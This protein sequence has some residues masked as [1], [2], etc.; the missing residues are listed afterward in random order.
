M[1]L[2]EGKTPERRSILAELQA[3]IGG[4][5]RAYSGIL[6]V[7]HAAIGFMFLCATFWF[8]N[9]G[10]AGLIAAAIGMAVGYVL[11]LPYAISGVNVYSSL[12]VGLSLGAFY[13]L[14]A[15]LIVLIAL[16]AALTVLLAAALRDVLWRLGR[17]PVLSVPFVIVALTTALAAANYGGLTPYYEPAQ[18]PPALMGDWI[19]TF[20][21]SLGSVFFSPHPIVGVALFLGIALR[22]RYLA[23][24]CICGYASGQLVFSLL[25]VNPPPG[26]LAWTGFNFAL[27]AMAVGGVFVVPSLA[28]FVLA[29]IAAGSSAVVTSALG[30][31]LL[32]YGLPVMASPFLLTTLTFLAALRLRMSAAAPVLLLEQ[33][34][35][36]ETNFERARLARRRLGSL[37]ST[38]LLAPFLGEWQVYQGFDGPHTH[39]DRWRYALDFHRLE[40]AV[41]YSGEG[42]DLEDY[43]CF[44]LPILSPAFGLVVNIQ[45]SLPDNL[46]GELD[47]R[48]NWGNY[49]LVQTDAGSFVLLAHLKKGS[50]RV[51]PGERVTP[52]TIIAKC[53]NSGRSP[54]PHVHLQVQR[55]GN[56]GGSTMPFHLVSAVTRR[57]SQSGQYHV[58]AEVDS[59][60][61]VQRAEDDRQLSSALHLPVGRTLRYR[62][63]D[64]K[65]DTQDS[66]LR[67]IVTLF[68]QFRLV[69]ETG[70]SAAFEH[71]N[72]TLA[73]YD[74]Q[75][76]A[77]QL[78]DLW[79][80]ALG[81]SPLSNQAL[82]W[83][84][85]PS[86]RL[87][88]LGRVTRFLLSC[89]H[90]LGMGI[91]S[92]Y[93]RQWLS[94][95]KCWKQN[96]THTIE[97]L[98][99]AHSASTV[100]VFDPDTGCRELSMQY[101]DRHWRAAL[102]AIGQSGDRGVR[103]WEQEVPVMGSDQGRLIGN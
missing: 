65:G 38:P 46:P 36:P 47:L 58:V 78:L 88:P 92:R 55:H 85:E 15:R 90:P 60:D 13:E 21:A 9:V 45:D 6:F 100:A 57:D 28:T 56:L 7:D 18:L 32:I 41:A 17:L 61:S 83:L 26:L 30:N 77:D 63:T 11:Q 81:L 73:F 79:L 62:V 59:G 70:A 69:G 25:T 64:A 80:L 94:A 54:Q 5:L 87:M 10:L 75:G 12:L 50:V 34:G 66:M 14:D 33:P 84:D 4:V 72:G 82:V 16:S 67:V 3:T 53:G 31:A 52:D 1:I 89:L 8:P 20:L 24:L 2:D 95:D 99:H 97:I 102:L 76:P 91:Q 101:H 29:L 35:L 37:A 48:N 39:Q 40:G 44:G 68:G 49:I 103:A 23:F 19:D 22:S 96:G 51:H 27:T 86:V 42:N 93:E 71:R 98:R 74:R 43:H